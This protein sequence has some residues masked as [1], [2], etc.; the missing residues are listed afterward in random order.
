ME[1][2]LCDRIAH[3]ESRKEKTCNSKNKV[4]FIAL[5]KDIEQ[6]LASGWSMKVIWET[7]KEEGKITFSYKTFRVFVSR[8][9]KLDEEKND[10]VTPE[11]KNTKDGT[12]K[13]SAAPGIPGFTF[14]PTPNPEELL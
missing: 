10:C 9:I 11:I 14:H 6:A 4:A 7:L 12:K 8:L 13:K 5:Q 1:Q 3:R 2:S